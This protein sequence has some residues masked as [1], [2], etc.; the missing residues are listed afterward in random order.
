M[1][2]PVA[3]VSNWPEGVNLVVA[4]LIGIGFG[5]FLEQGGFG[6]SRKLAL[7]FYFRDLTVFKVMFTAIITAMAGLIFFSAFGWIDMDLVSL[8]PTYAWSGIAGG[9]IMGVGFAVGG[10]CPGTGIV[11]LATLKTDAL[12]YLIG[13]FGGIFVFGEVEPWLH[14]FFFSGFLG[15]RLTLPQVLKVPAGVVGFGVI[16]IALLGFWGAEFLEKK[17]ARPEEEQ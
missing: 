6:N 3:I 8:N 4:F 17:F 2:G 12:F 14:R 5:F 10:Y 11:G 7:Q 1:N 15:D 13:I 9:L 16:V